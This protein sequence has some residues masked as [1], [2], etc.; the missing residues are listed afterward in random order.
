MT[1][2]PSGPLPRTGAATFGLVVIGT[3][4]TLFGMVVLAVRR[5]AVR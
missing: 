5:R 2:G 4:I 3:A 1:P